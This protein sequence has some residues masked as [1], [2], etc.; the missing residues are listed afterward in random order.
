[1]IG[2]PIREDQILTIFIDNTQSKNIALKI[3]S[4]KM[5]RVLY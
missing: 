5:T 2:N 1:M 3:M 4:E